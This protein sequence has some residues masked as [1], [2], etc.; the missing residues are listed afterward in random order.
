[1]KVCFRCKLSISESEFYAHPS[2]SDGLLGKCKACT[3]K[4]VSSRYKITRIQRHLY[5]KKRCKD[6]RRKY[7]VS[8]YQKIYKLQNSEKCKARQ[9]VANAL[10]DKKITKLPCESCGSTFRVQAHHDDYSK[11]LSVRWLCFKHHRELAHNQVVVASY[12]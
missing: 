9:F 3:K 2:M 12:K 1:M 8:E 11:P 4:D 7:L 5:E 6:T 10:R